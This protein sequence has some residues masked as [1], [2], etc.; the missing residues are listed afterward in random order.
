[1]KISKEDILKA[2][3]KANRELN[4]VGNFY[5]NTSTKVFTSYLQKNVT[6]KSHS[7]I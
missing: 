3:R 1:M 6:K 5:N 4:L 2:T 7:C